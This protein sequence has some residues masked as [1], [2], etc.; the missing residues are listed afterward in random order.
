MFNNQYYYPM[1]NANARPQMEQFYPQYNAN[2]NLY[3]PPQQFNQSLLQG[4]S[5]ESVDV[6]KVIEGPIDGSIGYYPLTDGTAIV[7]KQLQADGKTKVTIYKPVELDDVQAS[8]KY[9]TAEELEDALK[10]IEVPSVKEL[11][12]EL[13]TLKRQF[14]DLSDDL[15]DK[16]GD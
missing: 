7:S 2:A 5:V 11:K 9:V 4:K 12:E 14:R 15:K 6:A 3:T 1:G 8:V 10:Q 13:K 16:K